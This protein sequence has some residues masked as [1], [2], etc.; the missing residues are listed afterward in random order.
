MVCTQSQ[1]L[2]VLELQI[3][4]AEIANSNGA[5]SNA[6]LNDNAILV[7]DSLGNQLIVDAQ[8]SQYYYEL[9]NAFHQNTP[10]H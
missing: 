5:L 7:T 4:A 10:D 9:N 8:T 2:Q 1:G 3:T 6:N